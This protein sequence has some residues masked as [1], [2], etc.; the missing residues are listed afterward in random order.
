MKPTFS[1]LCARHAA[2]NPHKP[3][4]TICREVS[5]GLRKAKPVAQNK[6]VR[7]PYSEN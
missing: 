6:A 1:V 2:R 5:A 4:R 3:W 7:L